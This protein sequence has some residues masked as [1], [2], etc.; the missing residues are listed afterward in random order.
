[1]LDG[2]WCKTYSA[3][4]VDKTEILRYA[5]CFDCEEEGVLRLLEECL[6]ESAPLFTYRA[7]GRLFDVKRTDDDVFL[8]ETPM[9]S[10]ALA[11]RLSGCDRAVVFAATVGFGIDRLIAKYADVYT[12]KAYL[13]Q[14]VGAERVEALCDVVCEEIGALGRTRTRFSPGYGDLPLGTQKQV[15]EWLDGQKTLGLYLNESLSLTPTKSVTA[16]VGIESI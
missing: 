6:R 4:P 2:V 11:A 3:P 14:A 8:S 9:K 5:G 16:I 1:M 12:A 15:T 13:L 7:C 10:R